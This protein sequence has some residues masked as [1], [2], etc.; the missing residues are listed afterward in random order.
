MRRYML[1]CILLLADILTIFISAWISL[2]LRFPV[3]DPLYTRYLAVVMA[4]M[5]FLITIHIIFFVGF[6]L[7]QRVWRYA[8]LHELAV[9]VRANFCGICVS[10]L[11]FNVLPF[12]FLAN[13][14]IAR[15]I[16]VL[17]FFFNVTLICISRYCLRFIDYRIEKEV[18]TG[19]IQ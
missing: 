3:E 13:E 12:N 17:C 16:Y 15:S 10:Y 4:Y 6:R 7:Y 11:C 19:K 18:R 14:T 2:L 1:S 9:I 8:G 5:P